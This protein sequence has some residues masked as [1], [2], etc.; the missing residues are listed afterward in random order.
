MHANIK[1][2]RPFV[3]ARR[4][5][6]DPRREVGGD[7][8]RADVVQDE[9]GLGHGARERLQVHAGGRVLL[10]QLLDLLVPV[11]GGRMRTSP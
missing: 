6:S 2:Y 8:G 4:P 5:S 3:P 11:C 1:S 7:V 9:R 10:T